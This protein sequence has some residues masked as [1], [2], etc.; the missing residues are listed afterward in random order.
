MNDKGDAFNLRDDDF[1]DPRGAPVTQDLD[2]LIAILRQ[3]Q[4]QIGVQGDG[5]VGVPQDWEVARRADGAR[6]L[7]LTHCYD[8]AVIVK[9]EERRL[10]L[11]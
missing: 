10:V 4:Y 5:D 2:E 1:A 8:T 3:T 11:S 6:K 9:G 7:N